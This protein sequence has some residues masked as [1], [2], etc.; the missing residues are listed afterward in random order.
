M[1]T[2]KVINLLNPS[3]PA[4]NMVLDATGNVGIGSATPVY[5]LD[6]TGNVRVQP[7]GTVGGNVIAASFQPTGTTAVTGLF[8][9]AANQI[10]FGTAGAERMRI[11]S[12]GN[13]GINT[14]TPS[15]VLHSAVTYL[16]LIH[17]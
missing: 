1:S 16:S 7:P 3:S 6:I 10:A 11:N 14:V 9:P 17:I 15:T 8:L 12:V 2:L 13:V 5:S 4:T